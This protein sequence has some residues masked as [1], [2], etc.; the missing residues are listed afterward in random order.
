[1]SEASRKCV[2]CSADLPSDSP[3]SLCPKCLM[4]LGFETLQRN[5]ASQSGNSAYQPTFIAPTIEE[6]APQFPQLEILE[7]VGHG[8]MGVVYKARQIELDRIVALKI[9]RPGISHDLGFTERFQREARALAK[10]S[11]PNIIMV[12]DFGRRDSLFYF[13]MEF[14]EGANLRHIERSGQLSSKTA[15]E[16]VPQI[17]SAL[18]YAH[19]NG[20]VHRDIKPENI[21]LTK[22]GVVKIA[23]FGLAKLAGTTDH[24]PL[25]GTWQI[26]GT[27]HYM[28]PEQFEKPSTV[29]HRADI[30]SLGVV[31]YEMLTGE[32]PIGRF[33]LPSEKADVTTRLDD[34][35]MK[36][37]DKEPDRRYQ[38][39]TDVATAVEEATESPTP[40]AISQSKIDPSAVTNQFREAIGATKDWL[41]PKA[42]VAAASLKRLSFLRPSW[43]SAVDLM[44]R[45]LNWC[46]THSKGIGTTLLWV[47]VTEFLLNLLTFPYLMTPNA[48]QELM[49]IFCLTLAHSLFAFVGGRLLRKG[50]T[51]KV[52][53]W[54]L[55]FATIPGHVYLL[56]VMLVRVILAIAGLC[57]YVRRRSLSHDAIV[58][59]SDVAREGLPD[60][61][62]PDEDVLDRAVAMLKRADAATAF[63]LMR[64]SVGGIAGWCFVSALVL[65]TIKMVCFYY[66]VP[67]TFRVQDKTV[68]QVESRS[69]PFTEQQFDI[70]IDASGT[71]EAWGAVALR[72]QP[73]RKSMTLTGHSDSG[74]SV[75]RID[76]VAKTAEMVSPPH[77]S[78]DGPLPVDYRTVSR[79]MSHFVKDMQSETSNRQMAHLTEVCQL[80]VNTGGLT[81]D[82]SFNDSG[83]YPTLTTQLI[84]LKS[85][86]AAESRQFIP[87]ARLIDPYLF[88]IDA[89]HVD[90]ALTVSP[91]PIVMSLVDY[92]LVAIFLIGLLRVLK[93]TFLLLWKPAVFSS[94]SDELNSFHIAWKR[95]ASSMFVSGIT[96]TILVLAF[97]YVSMWVETSASR[98]DPYAIQLASLLTRFMPEKVAHWTLLVTLLLGMLIVVCSLL[99]H[100]RLGPTGRL[101]GWLAAILSMVTLPLCP[102]TFPSGYAALLMLNQG[103]S[104]AP[105]PG[106]SV[107]EP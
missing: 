76:F 52:V 13:I 41:T 67:A 24:T 100:P 39:V 88:H 80:M 47:G 26:M 32:L 7:V 36:S 69:N 33:R 40:P 105:T 55:L 20:V 46:G 48:Q 63:R 66:L 29:D 59:E 71:T 38:R 97:L 17:C 4:Q 10:L 90:L 11:H 12:Y 1:M 83:F 37:L 56:P 75:M 98:A 89:D 87:V 23:D 54:S 72:T 6:L 82:L 22:E 102:A 16:I 95:R 62:V 85:D 25:T 15:L 50:K 2:Q 30:Y 81:G 19:D 84:Q 3:A 92:S 45:S 79:W 65:G 9:L 86:A 42:A 21:L 104:G 64:W 53:L 27:P 5:A 74:Q 35:V 96:G 106:Q 101:F 31:I 18:Q 70:S 78:D 77:G 57:A 60:N 73:V 68:N 107:H 44:H 103:N 49:V 14:A 8:G 93:A 94:P 91:D 28:A 61:G 58:R 51:S 43:D 34:V 99:A